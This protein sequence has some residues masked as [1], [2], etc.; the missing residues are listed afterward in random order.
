ASHDAADRFR[1]LALPETAASIGLGK[2]RVRVVHASPDAP[3]VGI[4]V[5]DDAP[6]NPEIASLARFAD[7]A[8]V[9]LA[10]DTALPIGIDARGKRVTAFT[11]PNLPNGA[12]LT[13]IATGLLGRLPRDPSGF[14]LL[15]VG[16]NGSV[17]FI[18][19]NPYVYVLHGGVDAPD[20]DLCAG[21]AKI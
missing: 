10:P 16:P 14:A 6:A 8:G 4:D 2:A 17:G 12:D 15:A 13:I 3:S 9:E 11:T 5:G 18:K 19:Q 21:G 7:Q 20:V 1:V